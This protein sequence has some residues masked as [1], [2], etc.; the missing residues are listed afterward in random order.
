MFCITFYI[1]F[2]I[3]R[4]IVFRDFGLESYQYN[5]RLAG[6]SLAIDSEIVQVKMGE[7]KTA[8]EYP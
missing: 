7:K 3:T 2:H 8:E 1:G 5:Q 6:N 4:L